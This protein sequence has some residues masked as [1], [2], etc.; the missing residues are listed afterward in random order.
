MR[1]RIPVYLLLVIV[2]LPIVLWVAWP[3][4]SAVL[5]RQVA[6][7]YDIQ[8]DHI[9]LQRP[10]WHEL[11][12]E[13]LMVTLPGDSVRTRLDAQTITLRYQPAALLHGQLDTVTIDH[14]D[15]VAE[16]APAPTAE[17]PTSFVLTSPGAL[18][19]RLPL[20]EASIADLQ[21]SAPL[22]ASA[23][24]SIPTSA[25]T[26]TRAHGR[27]DYRQQ[28]L[29]VYLN[30]EVAAELSTT[31]K[32]ILTLSA[33]ADKSNQIEFAL[34][35][36]IANQPHEIVRFQNR[37]EKNP[38]SINADTKTPL[39]GAVHIDLKALGALISTLVPTASSPLAAM[40][41]EGYLDA[42][43][44]GEVPTLIDAQLLHATTLTGTLKTEIKFETDQLRAASAIFDSDFTLMEGVVTGAIKSGGFNAR[45]PAPA[46][47]IKLYGLKPATTLPLK[48]HSADNTRYRIDIDRRS[49]E[50]KPAK[51]LLSI[52]EKKSGMDTS[53]TLDQLTAQY[54]DTLSAQLH[55]IIK[56]PLV[57]IGK[58]GLR[59][60]RV[61]TD[62]ILRD[63]TL[64]G[65]W[66]WRDI[67]NIYQLNGN[68]RYQLDNQSG[69]INAQLTP[70]KFHEASDYLPKIFAHWTLPLDFSA[71]ELNA[72]AKLQW[73]ASSWRGSG[74]IEARKLGGFYNR[75]LIHDL[76]GSVHA[77]YQNDNIELQSPQISIASINVGVPISDIRFSI[78]STAQALL[79]NNFSAQLLGGTVAQP[80][81]RYLWNSPDQ[82][83]VLNIDHLQLDQILALQQNVEGTGTLDGVVPIQLR[84]G[85][86]QI[87]DALLQA[88]APGGVLRY[89]G[90][91]PA[92]AATN[93]G[94]ALAFTALQNFHYTAMTV[95]ASYSALE[96]TVPEH[97]AQEPVEPGDMVLR[98]ALQGRNPT[99]DS[100]PI[101]FNLNIK[102]NI[103]ALLRSLQL[104]Q[105]LSDR[106][107]QRMKAAR[108]KQ[109]R[110]PT[111]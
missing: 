107:E 88:R 22:L 23:S 4:W 62:L 71:G 110:S 7:A 28:K 51:I 14:L 38:D 21:I 61:E 105:D 99:A 52:R 75:N 111:P 30:A 17:K 64:G 49:I 90:D 67:A 60:A 27:L 80:Q 10:R 54:T 68:L 1:W 16:P 78:N 24:V 44:T 2:S 42:Q 53:I 70:L 77:R 101:N 34:S 26:P 96:R 9:S 95:R 15:V 92:S 108:Q 12:I 102:E 48:L 106:I 86:P 82:N 87:N 83:L 76:D 57:P 91:V 6:S 8:L 3:W 5:L 69:E 73:D 33:T 55:M 84:N 59:S 18:I 41:M 81:I 89:R 93:P 39:H 36:Q 109:Q 29:S 20:R 104:G 46:A 43:W 66:L 50:L 94:L 72:Q 98:V 13:Q 97:A 40:H 79:F 63:T 100:P 11:I 35:N 45:T 103:P 47:V 31:E 56:T 74:D 32:Q 85:T 25:S 37:L 65:T 58:L 19:A